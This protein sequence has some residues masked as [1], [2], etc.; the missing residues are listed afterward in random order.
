MKMRKWEDSRQRERH[1]GG[2][3]GRVASAPEGRAHIVT[4]VFLAT[5]LAQALATYQ[6]Q[7][8]TG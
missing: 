5:M 1:K 4:S 3:W 6:G 8:K 2:G 7:R